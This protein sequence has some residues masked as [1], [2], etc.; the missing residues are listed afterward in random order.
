MSTSLIGQKNWNR[1]GL[2]NH[3][4][5]WN[6][7]RINQSTHLTQKIS[8][9]PANKTL[10]MNSRSHY[11]QVWLY[12]KHRV[13]EVNSKLQPLTNC[14][15]L[16]KKDW[17]TA[18]KDPKI[19][20]TT[21]R[22]SWRMPSE[23]AILELPLEQPSTVNFVTPRGG[24]IQKTIWI[25]LLGVVMTCKLSSIQELETPLSWANIQSKAK[26]VSLNPRPPDR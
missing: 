26:L 12:L 19:V 15:K 1:S 10:G 11:G 24:L 8:I 9:I 5:N 22:W 20:K 14:H 25:A 16:S 6:K 3:M 21:P 7:R 17:L 2:P 13:T 23:A 18:K 4:P